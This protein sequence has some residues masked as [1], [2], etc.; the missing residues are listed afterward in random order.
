MKFLGAKKFWETQPHILNDCK[1]ALQKREI[2]E[3]EVLVKGISSKTTTECLM[4]YM[5]LLSNYLV[6]QDI[7]YIDSIESNKNDSVDAIVIFYNI[8]GELKNYW[9]NFNVMVVLWS[10]AQQLSSYGLERPSKPP[11]DLK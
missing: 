9:K 4:L 2:L 6:V 7:K 1:V 10:R 3:N 5:E 11:T 8:I